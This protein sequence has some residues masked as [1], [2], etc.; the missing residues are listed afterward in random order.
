M[1]QPSRDIIPADWPTWSTREPQVIRS[2]P[3]GLTNRSYLLAAGGERLVL[4]LNAHDS[5]TLDINRSAEAQA[6]TCASHAG[7]CAPLVHCDPQHRY[8]V[9]EFIDGDACQPDQPEH[10]E[11]LARLTADIHAL[12]EI[13]GR[14]DYRHKAETYWRAV[15]SSAE[16][17]SELVG[18]RDR[19][20]DHLA[21]AARLCD[22]LRLCHND[23]VAGNLLLNQRKALCAIDWEYAAMGDPFFDIALIVEEHRLDE[24]QQNRF[25]ERYLARPVTGLDRERVCHGRV[26]YRYLSLLWYAIRLAQHPGLHVADEAVLND[27]LSA[28]T[29]LL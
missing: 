22:S 1:P 21:A 2:L 12:P 3:G 13:R 15:D 9:T 17:Y 7:L 10:L 25:L 16:F 20:D 28:L 14:L 8:L 26:V 18:V 27:A 23:L 5:A 19:V 11:L 24:R 4:R 29:R 6:L